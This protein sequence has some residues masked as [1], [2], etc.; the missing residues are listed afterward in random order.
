MNGVE[1]LHIAAF[2]AQ[3]SGCPLASDMFMSADRNKSRSVLGEAKS[4]WAAQP[5]RSTVALGVLGAALTAVSL[6]KEKRRREAMRGKVVVI[7]GGSRGLGLTLAREFGRH[8]AHLVLAARNEEELRRALVS[9]QN[10]GAIPNAASALTVVCDVTKPEDC[11]R[12]VEQSIVRYGRV[13]VLVNNAGIIDVAPFQ[14]QPLSAFRESMEINFFGGLN[15]IQAVL[16]HM[17]NRGDGRIVNIASIGGKIGVPHLLPYVASKYA[18]V[19]FS[20]GLRA[21]L[22]GTGISVTTVNP[23]LMRTGSHVNAR[24][25]GNSQKEYE[26]FAIS[27]LIPGSST[28]AEAAA[29]QIYRAAADRTAEIDI[30]PQAWLAARIVGV[31][32]GI[33]A[34]VAGLLNRLLLPAPNGNTVAVPGGDLQQPEFRPVRK[35][36]QMLQA[37][38][39][40]NDAAV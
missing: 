24:F 31:A 13:D 4:R 21:E 34:N 10:A 38:H 9:L 11:A 28:S 12:V 27:N 40:A 14:D 36:S 18:L 19:G 22:S 30:T 17:Q 3:R 5:T 33:A 20:E 8:G 23:G 2:A 26:W 15:M 1:R 39:N 29:R 7:T 35:W 25:G 32:P 37:Q 16:P 6:L